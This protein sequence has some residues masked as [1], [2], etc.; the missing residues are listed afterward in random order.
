MNQLC[1]SD[2]MTDGFRSLQS[3]VDIVCA[4]DSL[5]GWN[6]FGPVATWEFATYPQFLQQRL[7]DQERQVANGGIAG[8]VSKNGPDQIKDYLG[9]FPNSRY[10]IIGFGTNDLGTIPDTTQASEGILRNLDTMISL[11]R[12][13]GKSPVLFNVPDV[14]KILFPPEMTRLC[15]E[16]RDFHNSRLADFCQERNLPLADIRALLKSEHLGDALHPNEKGARVIADAIFELLS[17]M[18]DHKPT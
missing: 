5:T 11:V 12:D 10:F 18:T 6:N 2:Q 1:L 7:A 15:D 8:E 9:L 16:K 14:N 17:T 4:G 13:A 3:Q